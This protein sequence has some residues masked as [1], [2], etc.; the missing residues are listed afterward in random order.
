MRFGLWLHYK[1][2]TPTLT[3][4]GLVNDL[5]E[6]PPTHTWWHVVLQHALTHLGMSRSHQSASCNG[7]RPS[8]VECRFAGF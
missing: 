4:Y 6:L 2:L 3:G 5:E 8:R 1:H 7:N